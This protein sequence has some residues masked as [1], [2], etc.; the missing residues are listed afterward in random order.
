MRSFL[1]LVEQTEDTPVDLI[2][3]DD[4]KLDLSITDDDEDERLEVSITRFSKLIAAEV[5]RVFGLSDGVE[6]FEFDQGEVTRLG[7]KL[8]LSLYPVDEIDSVTIGGV[9]L[10]TY[11]V[12]KERGLIWI[13]GG[14][15]SG[16]VVVTYSGGYDLPDDAPAGLQ[17]AVIEA[18]RG[19]RVAGSDDAEVQSTAT[20]D[21]RV[22]YFKSS[23]GSSGSLSQSVLDLLGP[24]RR[25][26]LA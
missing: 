4:L 6:T 13:N 22:T 7:Q 16:T 14:S 24:F 8:P 25:F 1:E 17:A 9:E 3:L 20:G 5:G 19:S 23:S 21:T 18:V 26:A 15:W 2:T 11:V 12:D 10:E